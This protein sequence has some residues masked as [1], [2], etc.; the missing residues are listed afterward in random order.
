[1]R[2]FAIGVLSLISLVANADEKEITCLAKNIYF[3]ARNEP[4]EGKY[5]V[6]MVTMNRV[7]SSK[8]PGN[9]CDVVYQ[10]WQFS[11]FWDGLS[12]EPKEGKAWTNSLW[13][14]ALIYDNYDL[15]L[16]DPTDGSLYYHAVYVNPR[17]APKLKLVKTI[18][19]HKFYK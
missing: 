1:M 6:A 17:W 12:D 7:A 10:Y 4:R 8:Y 2:L 15:G 5:G 3:E 19:L 13:L 18:G 16:A 14:A 9:V 11:W